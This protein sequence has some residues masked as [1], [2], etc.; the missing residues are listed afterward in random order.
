MK[1]SGNTALYKTY[2]NVEI[3]PTINE[4][5]EEQLGI[6]F[7]IGE[8]KKYILKNILDL[9]Q[10]FKNGSNIE[11]G[12]ELNLVAKRENIS[13]NSKD[14]LDFILEYGKNMNRNNIIDSY[15]R[16]WGA[17]RT[18]YAVDNEIDN[19]INLTE[20]SG[21]I[22]DT[23]MVNKT[24][25]LLTPE[26]P[27][28]KIKIEKSYNEILEQNEY[29][30]NL[31][32]VT[33]E[34]TT[35]SKCVYI[36]YNEKIYKCE[37]SKYPNLDKLL[38]LFENG[39]IYVPEDKYEDFYKYVLNYY[40]KFVET[41][42]LLEIRNNINGLVVDTLATKMLLD[43]D[44]N[45][46][47]I[48]ELKFCYKDKEFNILDPD[49]NEYVNQQNIVRDIPKEKEIL[50]KIFMDGFELGRSKRY[51]TLKNDED[52][53]NF[54]LNKVNDYMEKFE[55][56]ITDKLKNKKIKSVNV[57][58]VSVKLD[59]GLLQLDMSKINIDLNEIKGILQNYNIKKKY[60]KLKNGDFLN[61]E[62]SDELD[63]VNEITNNLNT[64]FEN[65]IAQ[66]P[67]N[68]GLY[69]EKILE[70]NTKIKINKNKEYKELIDNVAN[71]DF[72]DN[73]KVDENFENILRD[74][75]KVGYKWIKV[76]EHYKFGGILADDM[77]L[78]KTLQVISV[79][80][81]NKNNDIPSIV[82]CPSSLVLNWKKEIEK[83]SNNRLKTLIIS[84]DASARK[85]LINTYLDYDVLITSYDLLKRD[86][87]EY[88]GK[89]FK[90]IIADEAQYIKN[91]STQ[92]STALKTLN[93]EI[94]LALTGTPIENSIS[95]LWS[96][97]DFIMPGY[98]YSYTKF[99]KIFEQPILKDNNED[100]MKKF[101]TMI[102]PFI[103][104][105]IKSDVLTELPEKNITVMTNEMTKEQEKIYMSYFVQ[106][107]KEVMQ[108]L[109]EKG[110]EKSKF[111][112]LMLL[113]RLRQICC[114]PSLFI[115]NYNG[116]SGKLNQC[117]DLINEAISSNHKILLFSG[118]TS[119]FEIIEEKLKE[120]NIEYFK[121]TGS[122]PVDKR[123]EM[124]DDFNKND[125][126]KIFLISLKAGGTGLNLTSA[127]VVIHYDP[128]WN[129]SAENQATDR[130]Y[131]IGQKNSVQVYKL[132]TNNSI[133]EK[134][135]K[136]QERKAQISE[137]ILSTEETFINKLSKEEI[138]NLFD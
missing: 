18:I 95:E 74:Y 115:E 97:F 53:Y 113:T 72:S 123:I 70:R 43:L 118:Y 62:E 66:I 21:I 29:I 75:Q 81:S 88:E 129:V 13:D 68:R 93:G 101:K 8:K 6:E 86:I 7:K 22:V 117:M 137:K 57:S 11:F 32:I 112:I 121:L 51:F 49:F 100:A 28:I 114:H 40:N 128:W 106:T 109:N 125:N 35:S 78:G 131:R 134:I 5:E 45:N 124:V 107:K 99:K 52:M 65:G 102:S 120:K 92:N 126:V 103:L 15:N 105:R 127:D 83:W 17:N 132:I 116:E 48:M 80:A 133:E 50:E 39:N 82:V 31:N 135:N 20:K 130:A 119:M 73:I 64:K 54:L 26:E 46:N 136:L 42:Q 122:T 30:F 90:Y 110:F 3:I 16:Y 84:G 23:R 60:Y 111:K 108:Q 19:F 36:F 104:R 67:S 4:I 44:D 38:K 37:K 89:N 33:Y 94:K 47:I 55:I 1:N 71:K 14:I 61:L 87:D 96:I 76:L 9:Y 10:A 58:N 12:K 41:Q 27:E 85:N 79:L 77:G 138:M 63:F 98:L 91:F 24:K 59:G 56:L 34:Y 25:F 2:N 69:L